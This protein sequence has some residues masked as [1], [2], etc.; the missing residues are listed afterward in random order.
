MKRLL[1][2]FLGFA[3]SA[4]ALG[5][6]SPM[7]KS[8]EIA[9]SVIETDRF[10][11]TPSIIPTRGAPNGNGTASIGTLWFSESFG[12]GLLGDGTNG[13]WST[14]GTVSG[15]ADP[16]AK[17]EYR[18]QFTTPSNAIGSRG[19]WAGTQDPIISPTVSN[20][21]FIFDSDYLETNGT[22]A[23]NGIAG[24]P[25]KSWLIS[26][27]FS[28]VGS[29]NVQIT[30]NTFFR[31]FQG[32]CYVLLSNDNGVT[33]GDSIEIMGP[34]WP[35]N[36]L[37]SRDLVIKSRIPF[38]NN[39]T[40]AK[41]AFFF[42]GQTHSNVNGSGYYYAMID[43][44]KIDEV[45]DNDLVIGD[46]YYQTGYDTGL[47]GFYSII[48]SIFADE[49]SIQFSAKVV[50][51][52]SV[53]QEN[54]V[55]ENSISFNGSLSSTLTSAQGVNLAVGG[56]DS[57]SIPGF[58]TLNQGIG[59]YSFAYSMASDSTEDFPIDNFKDTV[60]VN[61]SDT[62]YARDVGASGNY[63][64]GSGSTYEVGNIFNVSQ[65]VK[66][67]SVS[68]QVGL[69]STAGEYISVYVYNVNDLTTAVTSSEFLALD[70]TTIGSFVTYDV[71]DTILTVGTYLVTYK[72][73]SDQVY[74]NTS[75]Y[76]ANQGMSL[77]NDNT[78]SGWAFSYNVYSVRLNI[79][80]NIIG[81][82]GTASISQAGN[83]SLSASIVNG[84]APFSYL[85][86]TGD[87]TTQIG[88]LQNC[89]N[90]SV[91]IT[92]SNSCDYQ[93]SLVFVFHDSVDFN[94]CAGSSFTYSDG[95]VITNV[96]SDT[97]HTSIL[98]SGGCDS[99][100]TE[101]LRVLPEAASSELHNVCYGNTF[102][103]LDGKQEINV[104]TSVSHVSVF[105]NASVNGCDS[106]VYEYLIPVGM[107]TI[108]V[109]LCSG[110]SYTFVDATVV[111]DLLNAVSHTSVISGGAISGCDSLIVENVTVNT[112]DVSVISTGRNL[113]AN[114][115]GGSYKWL[116]CSN[117][118]LINGATN[119]IFTPT[120]SGDYKVEVT[121]A[122]CTDTSTC[123]TILIDG[124]LDLKT[125]L[126]ISIYPN[127][128]ID[129]FKVDKGNNN[130]LSISIIDYS[131]KL[132]YQMKSTNQ[133]IAIDF[134]E[135]ASGV[136]FIQ[137]NN[138]IQSV[139][140]KLIKE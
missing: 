126:G 117:G 121:D 75:N 22:G 16:D 52:G 108:N 129:E 23:G 55:F 50:N 12:N 112:V 5:Q 101:N 30:L 63:W 118:N 83:D 54:V 4:M 11:T 3:C 79:N 107:S 1:L 59:E 36:Q 10:I 93:D 122:L 131:G 40:N 130:K 9:P 124:I 71:P 123:N 84:T 21:F 96:T 28:T 49:D 77:L 48:P 37:S 66:A 85:W 132:I 81:C 41:I 8:L 20:G 110:S 76:T 113:T 60:F 31:R 128:F 42:D 90:Y 18:G 15:V 6:N 98:T 87:T 116:D 47:S 97:Y 88:G 29:N 94:V 133:E 25:H 34:N 69:G 109:T 46:N 58:Y 86:S 56:S 139:V 82:N 7:V 43:D 105:A 127:P 89:I 44:I 137:I 104:V 51:N 114:F 38:L 33:W 27:S 78:G 57:L 135:F 115:V 92:D 91:T 74:F 103:Y 134:K 120:I 106:L 138:G 24:T 102:T 32:T 65:P 119:R 68:V 99:L 2:P 67:S 70:A 140:K 73:Y 80:T 14:N 64:F 125:D 45:V 53:T 17:W 100:V 35:L 19:Q 111:N 61:V 26:P 39:K 95:T 62:V 136:Y 72:T 13:T